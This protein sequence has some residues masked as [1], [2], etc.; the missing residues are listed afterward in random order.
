MPVLALNPPRPLVRRVATQGLQKALADT[1]MGRWGLQDET[2]VEDPAYRDIIVTQLRLCHGGLSD[3]GYQRM[4]EASLF[5]DEGMARTITNHLSRP[6][7]GT[8]DAV[9]PMISYTGGGHI[10]YQIPVPNR[11]LRKTGGALKYTTVYMTSLV[12]DSVEDVSQLLRDAIADYVWLTPV[13]AH[14]PSKR[15]R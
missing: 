6:K 8:D 3:D 10:Q 7:A 4:Y 2:F 11:V 13:S 14:G 1:D 12:P 15:C 5:R 9:G